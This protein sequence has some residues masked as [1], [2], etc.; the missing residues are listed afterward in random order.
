[1]LIRKAVELDA[2]AIAYCLLLA[3]RDIV[4]KL[5]GEDN[6]KRALTFMRDNVGKE[7]NQY[8]WQNCWVAEW[9]GN[10]IGAINIYNGAD[11]V[12]LREP[13]L[14]YLRSNFGRIVVPEDETQAGEYYIDTLAVHPEHRCKGV[15]T[16]LIQFVIEEYVTK[17]GDVLGLLVDES[18][19][20]AM[21]L[22]RK[23]GFSFSGV[24]VLLG[25]RLQHLQVDRK[26]MMTAPS[27]Q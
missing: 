3:M 19:V 22:Y 26:R 5:I 9:E 8:S 2:N 24:K 18:N 25:S 14:D 20:S 21:R 23:A 4:Y 16:Q 12:M 17:R 13:V 6:E 10:V 27:G 15:A 7:L 11:L 1:M